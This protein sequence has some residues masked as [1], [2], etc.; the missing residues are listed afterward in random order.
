MTLAESEKRRFTMI[1][2]TTWF[3]E[4]P[5]LLKPSRPLRASNGELQVGDILK[6]IID[7][8]NMFCTYTLNNIKSSD[9]K[10]VIAGG[11]SDE[12]RHLR[13]RQGNSALTITGCGTLGSF[14]MTYAIECLAAAEYVLVDN[15]QVRR[16]L[17]GKPRFGILQF[18]TDSNSFANK[19]LI[20][21]SNFGIAVIPECRYRRRKSHDI[22]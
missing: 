19:A 18:G 8:A 20:L 12:G 17:G 14:Q 16:Y 9:L 4:G 15:L 3:I 13:I 1:T 5:N 2:G 11:L 7:K 21:K 22:T 6:H 10:R